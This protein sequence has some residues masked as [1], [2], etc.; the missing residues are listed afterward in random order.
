[1]AGVEV[2]VVGSFECTE[3]VIVAA[4]QVRRHRKPFEILRCQRRFLIGER[5]RLVSFCP[6]TMLV[7]VTGLIELAAH[8]CS[9]GSHSFASSATRLS[10]SYRFHS[11]PT[12]GRDGP[13]CIE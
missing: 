4:D 9:D 11:E 12:K 1:L 10:F 13:M 8:A 5:K 7:A 2:S 3:V 6:G